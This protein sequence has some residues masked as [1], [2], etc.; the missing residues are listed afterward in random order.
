MMG[1]AAMGAI[2]RSADASVVG[3]AGG[4]IAAVA[5]ALVGLG[6]WFGRRWA[7]GAAFFLGVFWLWAALA[8]RIQGVMSGAEFFVWLA[9]SAA[10]I[11]GALKARA[12]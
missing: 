2:V 11:A 3:R 4:F 7:H 6:V 10:V 9:W 5:L 12:A 8:L 1:A